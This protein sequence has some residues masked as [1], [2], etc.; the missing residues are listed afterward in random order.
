MNPLLIRFI[1]FRLHLYVSCVTVEECRRLYTLTTFKDPI[2]GVIMCFRCFNH[3]NIR[4]IL[5][6]NKI[7][8]SNWFLQ[9]LICLSHLCVCFYCSWLHVLIMSLSYFIWISSYI[10]QP[11]FYRIGKNY[12]DF[13]VYSPCH[14]TWNQL[15]NKPIQDCIIKSHLILKH[16][17]YFTTGFEV[18]LSY[19]LEDETWA[20]IFDPN[21][22]LY[23]FPE[24]IYDPPCPTFDQC[25]KK[26]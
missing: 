6:D 2:N 10:S 3:D 19:N 5:H 11:F 13:E 1:L 18:V 9:L 24:K 8:D 20:T 26:R 21:G 16:M 15:G 12:Y 4:G 22:V 23:H 7:L 17:V 25:S 14:E